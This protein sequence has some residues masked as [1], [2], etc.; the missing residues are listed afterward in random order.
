MAGAAPAVGRPLYGGG[1]RR[2]Y[3]ESPTPPRR[4]KCSPTGY[5]GRLKPHHPRAARPDPGPAPGPAGPAEAERLL[6][7]EPETLRGRTYYL[8]R[9]EGRSGAHPPT[10]VLVRAGGTPRRGAG[11]I[12]GLAENN[13]LKLIVVRDEFDS[14]RPTAATAVAVHLAAYPSPTGLL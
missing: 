14:I 11:R 2:Y 12:K 13:H 4:F 6:D 1:G 3:S 9:R 7:G 5:V 10:T 8:V